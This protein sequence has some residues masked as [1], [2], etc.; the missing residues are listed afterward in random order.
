MA[1]HRIIPSDIWTWEAVI[2]CA[3]M[4]RLLFIGLWSFADDFGVQPLRPRTIRMQVFPDDTIENDSVRAMIDEL[5]ARKLVRVYEAEGQEYVE[6]VD[7]AQFQR[8]GTRASRRRSTIENHCKADHRKPPG[9]G[10]LSS[11]AQR[12]I[13]AFLLDPSLRSG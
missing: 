4:T 9:R 5:A 2:D 3:A 7:W 8:V 13:Y 6:V 1:R 10:I 12:G 11:G